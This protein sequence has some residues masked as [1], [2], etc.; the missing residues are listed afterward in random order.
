MKNIIQT[1]SLR[2]W[3]LVHRRSKKIRISD[4]RSDLQGQTSRS[5]GHVTHLTG[6]ANKSRTKRSRNT[7]IG[8]EVVHLTGNNAHQFQGHGHQAD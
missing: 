4:K 8:R 5:Q 1:S 3:N 6:V 7:K 2:T